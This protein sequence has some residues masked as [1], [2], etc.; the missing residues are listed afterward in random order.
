MH[1][2]ITASGR[3]QGFEMGGGAGISA[4]NQMLFLASRKVRA[5]AE[6]GTE[7]ASV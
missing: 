4:T 6:G 3:C 2:S 5:L 1:Y 7:L